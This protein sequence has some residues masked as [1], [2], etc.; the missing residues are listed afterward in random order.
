MRDRS[1]CPVTS[2]PMYQRLITIQYK[3]SEVPHAAQKSDRQARRDRSPRI[4]RGPGQAVPYSVA[5]TVEK[6]HWVAAPISLR[7]TDNV[8]VRLTGSVVQTDGA[9]PITVVLTNETT[10]Y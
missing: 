10:A 7:G 4:A 5:V 1:A 2:I 8:L 9:D 6:A 3:Q